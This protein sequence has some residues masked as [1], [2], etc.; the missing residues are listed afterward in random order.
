MARI[1][2]LA[3]D[4]PKRSATARSGAPAAAAVMSVTTSG[5]EVAKAISNVPTNRRLSPIRSA[6]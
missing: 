6:S 5:S 2:M 1:A 3:I 4:E